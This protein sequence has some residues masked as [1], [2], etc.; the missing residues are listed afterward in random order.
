MDKND[1]R[2][3]YDYNRIRVSKDDDLAWIRNVINDL[4][5][6]DKITPNEGIFFID[7]LGFE[8]K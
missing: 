3:R 1:T 5:R 4:F 6:E 8:K 2:K 7:S